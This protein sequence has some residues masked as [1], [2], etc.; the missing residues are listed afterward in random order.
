M[1]LILLCTAGFFAAMVDSI[2]GGGGLISVPAF[3]M[4]GFSPYLALGT[5]KFSSSCASLTSS[6]KFA[7]SGKIDFSIMKYLIP[8]TFM[9]AVLGVNTVLIISTKYLNMVVLILL[10]AVGCYSIFSKSAGLVDNFNTLTKKSI[11]CGMMLALCLGFYDGFF[12]PG[13]GSFLIFGLIGIYSFDYVRASGNAKLLNF[14]SNITS[15]F[16]FAFHHQINYEIGIPVAIFMI[17]GAQV[18]TNMALNKGA[19]FIKPIFITMSLAAACK[20]IYNLV[21]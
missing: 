18:G 4:A 1:T 14:I 12:G 16:L 15:L 7:R 17:I 2:A 5:N 20:M 8:F 6:I 21:S 11:F 3:L 13:T 10:L 9:G 19:R